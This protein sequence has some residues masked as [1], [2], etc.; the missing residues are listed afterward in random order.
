MS[1]GFEIWQYGID[2]TQSNLKL[3]LYLWKKRCIIDT[4]LEMSLVRFLFSLLHHVFHKARTTVCASRCHEL[5]MNNSFSALTSLLSDNSIL[6]LI[7]TKLGFGIKCGP[8]KIPLT[9]K[10]SCKSVSGSVKE[11]WLDKKL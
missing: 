2:K 9:L 1:T 8:I 3:S 6:L 5:P 10:V 7:L 11:A 4:L